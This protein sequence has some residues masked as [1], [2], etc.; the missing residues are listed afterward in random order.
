LNGARAA[1]KE[2]GY[3]A[4]QPVDPSVAARRLGLLVI[5]RPL[6]A[7][8]L[9]GMHL[10]EPELDEHLILVNS[11][12]QTFRQRFT[13][14]HEIGHSRFDRTTIVESL[15]QA[16][17]APEEKRANAFA[18]E[19]LMP[20]AAVKKWTPERAWGN[21]ANEIARLAI[22]F[23]L[24]FEATLWKLYN[25]SLISDVENAKNLRASVAP[26]LRAT[27]RSAGDGATEY[28]ERYTELVKA[29]VARGL[30]SRGRAAELLAVDEDF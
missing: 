29:G 28:P 10:Y 30:V 23:G 1:R 24:S 11:S 16:D 3:D 21:D 25:A 20:E 18:A 12:Q 22:H 4:L 6:R 19:F 15:D 17:S 8:T 26:D 5:R 14:A 27:L 13:L 2:L 7:A 9:W